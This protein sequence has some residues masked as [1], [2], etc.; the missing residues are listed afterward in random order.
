MDYKEV[1]FFVARTLTISKN[2]SNKK[3]IL[4]KLIENS[5]CWDKVVQVSSRHYVLPALYSILK[6]NELLH[7][8]PK[9]LVFYL[10]YLT[11]QNK[12]RNEKIIKQAKKVNALLLKHQITPIFIKGAGYLL[13]NLYEDFSERMI[14]DIDFLIKKEDCLK[15]YA[16]LIENGFTSRNKKDHI[17]LSHFRHL[18][19]LTKNKEIAAI[20]IHHELIIK[21]YRQE[22]SAEDIFKNHIVSIN[23]LHFL[24]Y[25]KQIVLSILSTQVNDG[26]SIF[27]KKVGLKFAYDIFLLSK[28]TNSLDA[29]KHYNVLFRPLNNYLALTKYALNDDSIKIKKTKVAVKFFHKVFLPSKNIKLRRKVLLLRLSFIDTRL[30]KKLIKRIA[31]KSWRNQKLIELG[32]KK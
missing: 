13:Q 16:I 31:R 27:I 8:L 29:I 6:K 21:E 9:D 25:E 18:P 11:T 15:A 1:F 32:L 12:I 14:G 3:W 4:H 19:R 20:E 28:K 5:I 24:N 23:N 22:F 26:E 7:Y 17:S 30:R 10:N 2:E